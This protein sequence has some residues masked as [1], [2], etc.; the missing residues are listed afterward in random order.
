M[1]NLF[2]AD[3][4]LMRFLNRFAD[5]ML[6]NLLFVGTSL[7]IVTLGASITALNATA[8]K[9]VKGDDESVVT[10]YLASFKENLR[11]GIV[12][13]LISGL[14][15]LVLVAWY[16]VI[17]NLNVP[18]LLR[19]ALWIAFSL[20]AFRVGLMLL[21]VF[22]YQAAFVDNLRTVF[23]NARLMSLRH[24]PSSLMM[25]VVLGLPIVVSVFYPQVV[26][27][28]LLWLLVGFAAVAYANATFLV[29]I[30]SA[31]AHDF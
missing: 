15:V 23:R 20:V 25:I 30:F 14:L 17:E 11:Q 10:T 24:L 29:R 26:G 1:K 18:E 3:S 2:A 22:P 9:Q 5:F 12:L 16:V 31:Y 13:G 7:P 8:M 19:V 6:V 27:Y 21:Y 28:G 4:A